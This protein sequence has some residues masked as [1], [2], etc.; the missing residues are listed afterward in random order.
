MK[1]IQISATPLVGGEAGKAVVFGLG[2]DG[3]VYFWN[4]QVK[5]W[6]PN[7]N[8]ATA[9]PEKAAANG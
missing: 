9:A 6:Q 5:G 8:T 4:A 7:W 2:D 3:N 1:I